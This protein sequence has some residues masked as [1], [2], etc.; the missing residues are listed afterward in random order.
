MYHLKKQQGFTLI[1]LVVVIVILGIL[2]AT[3]APKFIDLTGDARKSTLQGVKGA[4]EGANN[5]V[6]S[7]AIIDGAANKKWT[8]PGENGYDYLLTWGYLRSH[9]NPSFVTA[10]RD[11]TGLTK[12]EWD[13]VIVG[14][15][16]TTITA[17][18]STKSDCQVLYEDATA[19]GERPTI[20]VTGSGC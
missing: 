14:D 18:G 11:T 19:A 2:A 4:L 10:F 17:A 3:A 15:T 5:M 13:F 12:E 1:E 6:F 9:G 16:S 20:T 8:S 7:K